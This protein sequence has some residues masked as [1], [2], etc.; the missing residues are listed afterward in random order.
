MSTGIIAARI[1]MSIMV[2]SYA[3]ENG[4]SGWGFGIGAF[5]FSPIIAWIVAAIS[6]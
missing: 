2:G 6:K 4:L 5:I 3:K 1:V